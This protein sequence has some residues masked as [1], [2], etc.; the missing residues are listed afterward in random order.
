MYLPTSP[1]TGLVSAGAALAL[2][3]VLITTPSPAAAGPAMSTLPV[4]R[5]AS[6]PQET[7]YFL[8][9]QSDAIFQRFRKERAAAPTFNAAVLARDYAGDLQAADGRYK[10]KRFKL[11]ATVMRVSL[12]DDGTPVLYLMNH[13]GVPGV[14]AILRVAPNDDRVSL[15]QQQGIVP[16]TLYCG[17]EGFKAEIR[18]PLVDCGLYTS[19]ERDQEHFP[20][21]RGLPKPPPR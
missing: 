9:Q 15:M 10:G 8:E 16:L 20:Q 7:E 12:L 1:R 6:T 21:W 17:G 13:N 3:A 4:A 19:R 5:G 2:L 18:M 11:D 14:A